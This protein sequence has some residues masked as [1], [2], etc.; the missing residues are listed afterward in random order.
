MSF[1]IESSEL[2]VLSCFDIKL[3]LMKELVREHFRDPARAAD[4]TLNEGKLDLSLVNAG[5][6][7]YG[8]QNPLKALVYQPLIYVDQC[9]FYCELP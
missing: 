2:V 8:A 7:F 3:D 1:S 5:R 4:F 6:P 9:F